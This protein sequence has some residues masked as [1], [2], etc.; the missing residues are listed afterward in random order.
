MDDWLWFAGEISLDFVNTIRDRWGP[1]R[2]T[3]EDPEQLSRWFAAAGLG[4][5]TGLGDK[6][7]D[8]ARVLRAAIS[9]L[10]E[11][12]ATVDSD[13]LLALNRAVGDGGPQHPRLERNEAGELVIVDVEPTIASALS[14]VARNAFE[15]FGRN[16]PHR[17]KT[18]ASD[19]CGIVFFDSSRSASRRWCSMSRCG[20]RAKVAGHAKRTAFNTAG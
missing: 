5:I 3:L 4:S 11:A 16:S 7:L 6:D 10:L 20:N 13:D 18:C 14:R 9:H 15:V 1:A 8:Q 12:P 19:Q 17:I 2:E